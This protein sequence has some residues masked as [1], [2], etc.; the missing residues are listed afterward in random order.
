MHLTQEVGMVVQ[1][2][3][4]FLLHEVLVSKGERLRHTALLQ[5]TVSQDSGNDI[6][7]AYLPTRFGSLASV[8][9]RTHIWLMEQA[10]QI[11]KTRRWLR[12]TCDPEVKAKFQALLDIWEPCYREVSLALAE[13]DNMTLASDN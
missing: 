4:R 1:R 8:K 6:V 3:G 7:I 13:L 9:E 12:E 11:E 5:I 2:Y 10:C